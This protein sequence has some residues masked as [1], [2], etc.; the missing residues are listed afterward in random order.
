MYKEEGDREREKERETD[1]AIDHSP[2]IIIN[3]CIDMIM[4]NHT[5]VTE[6]IELVIASTSLMSSNRAYL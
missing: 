3:K 6:L 2:E 1:R 4:Y 5:F